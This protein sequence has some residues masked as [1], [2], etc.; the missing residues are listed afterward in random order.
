MDDNVADPASEVV[1]WQAEEEASSLHHG[2]GIVFDQDGYLYL[3]VGDGDDAPAAQR[4]TT[5]RGKVLRLNRDGSVP[6]DNPFHDGAGPNLDGIYARGLRNPY[7]LSL[8]AATGTI[9]VYDVGAGRWEEIN[10]LVAGANYGWAVCEGRCA[11]K[12]MTDPMFAYPHHGGIASI[13]GGV[14]YRGDLLPGEYAG[15]LFYGDFSN[16]WI[17]RLV[18]GADGEVRDLLFAP[19]D[20]SASPIASVVDFEVGPD[21]ALYYVDFAGG[22]I[23]RVGHSADGDTE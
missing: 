19:A 6:G 17:R 10:E 1:L 5:Y 12:G 2:G 8:D 7:R 9:H 23:R 4:L 3:G 22:T 14:V 11:R 15:N 16:A 18:P 13:G 21:G 20:R